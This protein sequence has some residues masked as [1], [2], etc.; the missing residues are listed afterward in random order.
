MGVRVLRLFVA[1]GEL[2]TEGSHTVW[3]KSGDLGWPV[4]WATILRLYGAGI[5]SMADDRVWL[6]QDGK[7]ILRFLD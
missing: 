3:N 2:L 4:A 5:V 6:T 1:W 7:L